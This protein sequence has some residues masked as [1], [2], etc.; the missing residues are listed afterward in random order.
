MCFVETNK[1]NACNKNRK[2]PQII[3]ISGGFFYKVKLEIGLAKGKTAPD[4]RASAKDKDWSRQKQ[5][6]LKNQI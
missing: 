2:I 5:R 4:K 6:L 1:T 3:T